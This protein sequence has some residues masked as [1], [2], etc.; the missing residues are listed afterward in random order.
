MGNRK[1]LY[2]GIVPVGSVNYSSYIINSL[3]NVQ[4]QDT[5]YMVKWWNRAIND[6]K[7]F[8]T[9]NNLPN[10]LPREN[11]DN[12]IKIQND[13]ALRILISNIMFDDI[14]VG[15]HINDLVDYFYPYSEDKMSYR[16]ASRLC[17]ENIV[18]K[19][20]N[21][22]IIV[23]TDWMNDEQINIVDNIT[24]FYDNRKKSYCVVTE[25]NTSVIEGLIEAINRNELVEI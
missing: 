15:K 24:K 2:L 4:I 7:E 11:F 25:D 17:Y 18:D 13:I 12:G 20:S 22:I 6:I 19:Y 1:E 23:V 16:E 8:H 10:M 14:G 9:F 3:K 21:Y 5:D